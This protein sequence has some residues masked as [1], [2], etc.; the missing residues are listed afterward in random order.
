MMQAGRQAFPAVV[1][2][3]LWLG[4]AAPGP[5]SAGSE[6]YS[7][8]S[9]SGEMVLTDDAGKIPPAGS[10]GPVSVHRFQDPQ[11]R[12][13]PVPEAAPPSHR[14]EGSPGAVVASSVPVQPASWNR[15]EQE[16]VDPAALEMADVVLE[17]PEPGLALQYGWVSLPAPAYVWSAPTYG[18]WS[19]RSVQ[20]PLI[21]LQKHLR[22]LNRSSLPAQR[23]SGV[24]GSRSAGPGFRRPMRERQALVSTVRPSPSYA[25]CCAQQA[26]HASGRR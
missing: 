15:D 3:A 21:A 8:I 1:A 19:R 10:R 12:S 14:A 2:A 11:G 25:P 18:F 26:P 13:T 7:W 17:E 23:A 9:T 24:F 5:A 20:N 6:F 16:A 22:M 4:L